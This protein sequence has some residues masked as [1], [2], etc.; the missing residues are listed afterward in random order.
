M[1]SLQLF[2]R[3]SPR[4]ELRRLALEEHR[5]ATLR[6]IDAVSANTIHMRAVVDQHGAAE[7]A[8]EPLRRRVKLARRQRV[9]RLA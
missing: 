6:E 4:N 7:L 5:E 9:Q 1:P 2:Q 8:F 3:R